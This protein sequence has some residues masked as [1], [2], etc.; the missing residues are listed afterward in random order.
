MEITSVNNRPTRSTY[1][2]RIPLDDTAAM[3][4]LR[5]F[6]RKSEYFITELSNRDVPNSRAKKNWACVFYQ[7]KETRG[8]QIDK[9]E[10]GTIPGLEEYR[11]SLKWKPTPETELL[12]MRHAN[13]GGT[14]IR[15]EQFLG[16]HDPR[17]PD[18]VPVNTTVP[19]TPGEIRDMF[20]GEPVPDKT[21]KR[22]DPPEIEAQAAINRYH[23]M[24]ETAKRDGFKEV[25]QKL[26]EFE[27]ECDHDHV[28]TTDSSFQV[29]YCEDCGI[30]WEDKR[31]LDAV[32]EAGEATVVGN[33]A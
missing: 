4:R 25:K 7:S 32:V 17:L 29:A 3:L 33:I 13:G 23:G 20:N 1:T 31:E 16:T 15:G 28:V 27:K 26:R 21:K 8:D 30:E 22:K 24:I 6:M 2:Y 19:W 10:G 12:E 5:R 11:H 18:Y 14:K 9:L